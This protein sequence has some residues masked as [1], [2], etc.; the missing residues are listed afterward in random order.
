MHNVR[1][2]VFGGP[3]IGIVLLAAQVQAQEK[4]FNEMI[5]GSWLVTAVFDEYE[6]GEKKDNWSGL[7]KGQITFGPTGRFTTILVGPPVPLLKSKDP[8]K[9]DAKIA[10]TM[11]RTQSTKRAKR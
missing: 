8:R 4:S 1:I 10:P 9:P 11:D 6:N 7:V 5:T 3:L 2:L